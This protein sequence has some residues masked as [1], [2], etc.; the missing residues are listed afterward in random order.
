[1]GRDS[2]SSE[3]LGHKRTAQ[4]VHKIEYIGSEDMGHNS[5]SSEILIPG[6]TI[7]IDTYKYHDVTT[8]RM[9]DMI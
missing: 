8:E 2:E 3:I 4:E 9:W 7:C 6:R 5:E 1:M